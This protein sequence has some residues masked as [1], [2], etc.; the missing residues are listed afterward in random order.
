M[1]QTTYCRSVPIAAKT[2]LCNEGEMDVMPFGFME[3]LLETLKDDAQ[4]REVRIGAFWTAVWSENCGLASTITGHDHEVG[5]PVAQAG[6]LPGKSAIELC[7]LTRSESV[8]ERCIG[9]AAVNSLLRPEMDRCREVNA[10]EVLVSKGAGRRV[11][12]VGHFPFIPRLRAVV[13]QLWVL[14]QRPRPGDLSAEA[15]AEVLPMADVVAITG[16]ALAN[17]TMGALLALCRPGSLVM[18]LG[19]TTPLTPLWF[20]YGVDLVSGSRVVNPPEVLHMVGEG[21]VFTQLHRR[22]VRL[23]TMS[24]GGV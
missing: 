24:K 14:E 18:V 16:T 11:A 20:D 6:S 1:C 13:G 4:V 17:G 15:A 22:G 7:R 2:R 19:P 9:I 21:A 3:D 12:V 8:L 23:L 10:A 5:A